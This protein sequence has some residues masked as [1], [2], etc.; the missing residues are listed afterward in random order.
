[1]PYRASSIIFV[2]SWPVKAQ[3]L[4][5]VT[6]LRIYQK[7]GGKSCCNATMPAHHADLF[8]LNFIT[9]SWVCEP[10]LCTHFF[11]YYPRVDWE[12]RVTVESNLLSG[13]RYHIFTIGTLLYG[14][15]INL[16]WRPFT[17]LRR[18]IQ[19]CLLRFPYFLS[20]LFTCL[21]HSIRHSGQVALTLGESSDSRKVVEKFPLLKLLPSKWASASVHQHG[22][23][24]E[25]LISERT[26]T[27]RCK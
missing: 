20:F 7:R 25:I 21:T 26:D 18:P 27:A 10:Y 2:L 8:W 23:Q 6:Y 9:S 14:V 1:M 15:D 17:C 22:R 13:I 24:F 11:T 4:W 16:S 12:A 19:L 3:P 5:L